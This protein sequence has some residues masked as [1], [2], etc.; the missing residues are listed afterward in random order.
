MIGSVDYQKKYLLNIFLKKTQE[1]TKAAYESH[2]SIHV[3]FEVDDTP[4]SKES[5]CKIE[6]WRKT[7]QVLR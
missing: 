1:K 2:E 3:R 4:I 7:R 5:R 6:R